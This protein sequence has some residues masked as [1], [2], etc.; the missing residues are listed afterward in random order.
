MEEE[1]NLMPSKQIAA[2]LFTDI[3]G[4]VAPQQTEQFLYQLCTSP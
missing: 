3:V 2:L 1:N 4:S